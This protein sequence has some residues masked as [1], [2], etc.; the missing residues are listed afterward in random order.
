MGYGLLWLK[1]EAAERSVTHDLLCSEELD[2]KL[3]P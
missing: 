1:F 2:T 3:S